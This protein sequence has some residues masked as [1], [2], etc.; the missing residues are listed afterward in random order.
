MNIRQKILGAL[1]RDKAGLEEVIGWMEDNKKINAI[2]S[3][4]EIGRFSIYGAPFGLKESK[5]FLD[6]Y[7]N[8]PFEAYNGDSAALRRDVQNVKGRPPRKKVDNKKNKKESEY[9]FKGVDLRQVNTTSL[10]TLMKSLRRE[11]KKRGEQI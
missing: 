1:K 7:Y 10:R 4:R 2:K 6:H 5:D 3:L 9:T 8:D 11:L